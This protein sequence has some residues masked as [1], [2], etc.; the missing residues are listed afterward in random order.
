MTMIMAPDLPGY[1]SVADL[2]PDGSFLRFTDLW[3]LTIGY[4]REWDGTAERKLVLEMANLWAKESNLI[5]ISI[6]RPRQLSL[7][8]VCNSSQI[9]GLAFQDI[10]SRRWEGLN[11][12]VYDYEMSGFEV[13]CKSIELSRGL[14]A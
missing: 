3:S 11:F 2:I 6:S 8:D 12:H 5:Q 4:V 9:T 13:F 7:G 1:E 14:I 10:R